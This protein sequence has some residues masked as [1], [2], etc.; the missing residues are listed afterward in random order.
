MSIAL[1]VDPRCPDPARLTATSAFRRH[2]S[3]SNPSRPSDGMPA[4][5]TRSSS[6]LGTRL[7]S[8]MNP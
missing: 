5:R 6:A 1:K 4:T 2:M 3:E 8:D 7:R